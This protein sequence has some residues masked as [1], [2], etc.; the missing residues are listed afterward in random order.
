M[1]RLYE[2]YGKPRLRQNLLQILSLRRKEAISNPDVWLKCVSPKRRI[3]NFHWISID[4]R[5]L[6]LPI[7]NSILLC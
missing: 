6:G 7:F 2:A 5:W 3:F 4:L 1:E